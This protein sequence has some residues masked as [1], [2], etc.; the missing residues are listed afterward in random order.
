MHEGGFQLPVPT[1]SWNMIENANMFSCFLK[2]IQYVTVYKFYYIFDIIPSAKQFYKFLSYLNPQVPLQYIYSAV[3]SK[4]IQ[5]LENPH[6]RYPIARLWMRDMQCLLQ[7]Q[8]LIY[9][10]P[11]SLQYSMQYHVIFELL[12]NGTG[13]YIVSDFVH[14]YDCRRHHQQVQCWLRRYI[15]FFH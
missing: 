7:V 4:R 3:Q 11:E 9:T 13:L 6:D 10:M 5:L 12:F 1:Q 15:C 14:H 8:T 2:T